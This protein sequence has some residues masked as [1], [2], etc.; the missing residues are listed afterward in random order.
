[1]IFRT[2]TKTEVRVTAAVESIF[3]GTLFAVQEV[4]FIPDSGVGL[5]CST[6]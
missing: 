3:K 6:Y 1:M 2:K 5:T 4:R